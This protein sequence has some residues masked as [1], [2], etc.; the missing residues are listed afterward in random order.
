MG[1]MRFVSCPEGNKVLPKVINFDSSPGWA[2][3]RAMGNLDPN[4][5]TPI[6]REE[7]GNDKVYEV[8]MRLASTEC[9]PGPHPLKKVGNIF[10][11]KPTF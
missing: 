1:S 11:S 6:L 2:I 7:N 8:Q 9:N 10:W 5:Y 4:S 3:S